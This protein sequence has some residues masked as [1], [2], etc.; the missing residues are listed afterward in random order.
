MRLRY[1]GFCRVC[2]IALPARVEAIYERTM[3]T[4]RCVSHD[5]GPAVESAVLAVIE[6][7]VVADVAPT[8]VADVALAMEEV[9]ESG[10][11]LG[12]D[13]P[14]H[15]VLC[16]VEAD[17]PLIGGSFTTQGVQALWPKKLY[18]ALQAEGRFTA[19]TVAEMHRKLAGA[20]RV[21]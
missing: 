10:T 14:V 17:W 13:V 6:R 2:G 12:D 11:L 8:V 20:L 9:V 18:P 4:V 7:A 19:D 15:G 21:A 1:A 3:K 16:F 5:A